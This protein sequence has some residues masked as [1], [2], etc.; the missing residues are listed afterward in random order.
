MYVR[1]VFSDGWDRGGV[2]VRANQQLLP[3][4]NS[5]THNNPPNNDITVHH[6][7]NVSLWTSPDAISVDTAQAYLWENQVCVAACS[8]QMVTQ[9]QKRSDVKKKKAVIIHIFVLTLDYMTVCTWEESL[10]V[11]NTV[12]II[13]Q[14][15]FPFSSM[16]VFLH[17]WARWFYS[18]QQ[19]NCFASF[20]LCLSAPFSSSAG[21][22]LSQKKALKTCYKPPASTKQHAKLA[23]N[24]VY[25]CNW[26][27]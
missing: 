26:M 12:R 4:S 22:S 1:T 15:Q 17:I 21:S 25:F 20:P 11:N 19:H 2:S 13:T 5:E 10:E 23:T 8:Q 7:Y 24:C 3:Y 27:N 9:S 16:G 6:N 18:L 14:L